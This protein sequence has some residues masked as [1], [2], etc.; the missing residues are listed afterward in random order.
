MPICIEF[1]LIRLDYLISSIG[2]II[3]SGTPN[4]C[5]ISTT[6]AIAASVQLRN[7]ATLSTSNG[8]TITVTG[9]CAVLPPN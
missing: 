1:A 3:N 7:G 5:V 4:N 8:M 2:V 6:N 9:N